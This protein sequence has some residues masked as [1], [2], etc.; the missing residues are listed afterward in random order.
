M[1]DVADISF[2][3]Q[4]QV[5]QDIPLSRNTIAARVNE[6]EDNLNNHLKD[7]IKEF[8]FYSIAADE[9]TDIKDTAQLVV[10]IRGINK[11]FIITKELLK[12]LPLKDTTTAQDIYQAIEQLIS[13]NEPDWGK[14]CS[15]TTDGAPAMVGKNTS[16]VTKL[17]KKISDEAT[18]Q[19]KL[20]GIHCIIHQESLASKIL[21][22]DHVLS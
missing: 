5:I 13:I 2:A 8:I 7:K 17:P 4:K 18:P 3:P 1:L 20:I 10:F 11:D 9:S 15:I 19:H 22:M 6:L 16:V 21:K 12:C 14:L